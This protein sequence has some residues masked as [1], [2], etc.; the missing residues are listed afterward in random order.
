MTGGLPGGN[1]IAERVR[2]RP[3]ACILAAALM[4]GAHP[5]VAAPRE[6]WTP[7]W[8]ASMWK[9]GEPLVVQNGTI[10][11]AVR[12]NAG[13]G[14]LRLRLS[15]EYGEAPLIIGA[16]TVR[17]A[18]GR[19]ARVSFDGRGT[20][21]IAAGAPL[22]SDAVALAVKP[23]EVVEVS[24]FLPER[25]VL[26]T[27]HGAE[28]VPTQVSMNGDQTG[29]AA[30][31]ATGKTDLR[32]LIAQVDVMAAAPRPVIVAYGDSITDATG[33]AN[34]APIVCRWGDALAM[35]LHKAGRPQ[36]VVTQAISGNRV[37]TPGAGPNALARF[38][39]DVLSLPG[40]SHVVLLEAIND[41]GNSGMMRSGVPAP[42]V[43]AEALIAGYRQIMARA[44]DHG[45]KVVAMTILPFKG[46]GYFAPER[47]AI[48]KRVN[49]WIRTGGG[50]DAVVDME[51]VM[52]DPADSERLADPLQSG[53]DLHPNGAGESAM[54]EAIPLDL[55]R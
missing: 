44:H 20:A 38:D 24:I 25:S 51:R 40:V 3:L 49:A 39:R 27:V 11:A 54:A 21:R 14:A 12:V 37:L 26:S 1:G 41:I 47:E 35:R 8:T 55:F 17:T 34:D 22:V 50:F 48:R 30:F 7:A 2:R 5:A 52:A 28:G 18:D 43:T 6:S 46:A 9:P 33:C 31:A 53:D 29:T 32:P 15:N 19:S 42:M 4:L 45:I 16:A 36:V 13:G 10:R 23:F